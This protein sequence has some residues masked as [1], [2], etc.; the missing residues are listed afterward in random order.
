M[1]IAHC[2]LF[3]K[4]VY[5]WQEHMFLLFEHRVFILEDHVS[6]SE[7]T[8]YEHRVLFFFTSCV[9]LWKP[10][11]GNH[12]L[13]NWFWKLNIHAFIGHAYGQF[14]EH[15]K[16]HFYYVQWIKAKYNYL[17]GSS[18]WTRRNLIMYCAIHFENKSPDFGIV[19]LFENR[20]LLFENVV[21]LLRSNVCVVDIA[22]GLFRL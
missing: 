15:Q 5:A 4:T 14:I 12:V 3:L 8:C 6:T 16:L 22:S 1:T 2:S 19:V 9:L 10:G 13:G 7:N 17:L 20:V 18:F 21:F 11:F